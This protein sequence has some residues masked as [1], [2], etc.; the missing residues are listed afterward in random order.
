[1]SNCGPVSCRTLILLVA[2]SLL[3]A[4]LVVACVGQPTESPERA[5]ID[6]FLTLQPEMALTLTAWPTPPPLI[7]QPPTSTAAPQPLWSVEE[8]PPRASFA[9]QTVAAP[10]AT[11]ALLSSE[12]SPQAGASP[13]GSNPAPFRLLIPVLELDVPIVEVSW[14]VVL[15]D[16]A[17]HSVWQTADNAVGHHRNSANP[18]EAGN[19]VLS[20]HHNTRGEVFRDV[21]EIGFPGSPLAEGSELIVVSEDGKQHIYSVVDWERIQVEGIPEAE[22]QGLA[23]YL[24]PTEEPILTMITCWPYESNSHRVIVIAEFQHSQ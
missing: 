16:N 22:L 13:L 18:G 6:R 7:T 9:T 4:G 1:M 24:A 14:D 17:W 2:A 20:G 5:D 23:R 10:T 15:E 3:I 21:S 8:E 19:V 11:S 12:G